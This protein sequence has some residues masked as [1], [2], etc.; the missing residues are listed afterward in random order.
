[1][2]GVPA[3]VGQ[4]RRTE[5]GE[6]YEITDINE[7]QG[8]CTVVYRQPNG[9]FQERYNVVLKYVEADTV[10]DTNVFLEALNADFER[11]D[12][13]DYIAE[14]G[15]DEF[16]KDT[17]LDRQLE[18]GAAITEYNRVGLTKVATPPKGRKY[19]RNK[20]DYTLLPLADLEGV[21]RV[22]EHGAEKYDR[23]NWRKVENGE[24]R[25]LAAAL[26]HLA[27]DL[28]SPGSLDEDSGLPH[29]DHAICSLIFV[30]GHRGR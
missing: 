22:L 29:L 23:H 25:Y 26:R 3:R 4:F 20:P 30:R 19:D 8:T 27:E 11:D 13:D 6:M 14:R 12:V 5:N 28:E 10:E 7:P 2:S 24:Q 17:S 15:L 18:S 9:D 1:M 21:V 16:I